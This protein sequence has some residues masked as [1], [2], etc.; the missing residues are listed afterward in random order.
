MNLRSPATT[1]IVVGVLCTLRYCG[2]AFGRIGE[3][4]SQIERRYGESTGRWDD[5]LGYVKHYEWRGFTVIV[6]F[7]DG[8]SQRESFNRVWPD[9]PGRD[10]RDIERQMK[11]DKKMLAEMSGVGKNGVIPADDSGYSFT[12]RAFER[13]YAAAGKA[14]VEKAKHDP[15]R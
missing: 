4:E 13:K 2:N 10:N 1:F 5:V 6:S 11:L 9:A 14:T 15:G 12:T 8:V 3:N 7:V